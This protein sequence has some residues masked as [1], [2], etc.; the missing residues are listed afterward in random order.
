[1]IKLFKKNNGGFT[2]VETLVALSIFTVSLLGIMSVLASGISNTNYS[3]QKIIAGYLAQEGIEYV[4]NLRD[5]AVLYDA[6]GAQAGWSS[7]RDDALP[8]L[9]PPTSTSFS[10]IISKTVTN[11]DEVKI[12]SDV[13]W[14]QGSGTFHVIFSES[15][16]NWVE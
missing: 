14:T 15:L 16:F 10:R 6:D 4:R 13:S 9:D 3:K 7:F 2:L 11:S 12:S 5:T 8:P 1:M